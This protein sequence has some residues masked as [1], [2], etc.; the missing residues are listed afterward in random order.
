MDEDPAKTRLS[1]ESSTPDADYTLQDEGATIPHGADDTVAWSGN[2]DGSLSLGDKRA[3]P[4]VFGRYENLHPL[5]AGGA[6]VVYEAYDRNLDRQVALKAL[7]ADTDISDARKARFVGEARVMA[8]LEHP[9][10]VPVHE[11]NEGGTGRMYFTMKR[12]RGVTL[13]TIIEGLDRREADF[14]E[15]YPRERLIDIFQSICDAIGFAHDKGYIHRD[16]KPENILVGDF[17]EVQ[18]MDWG[19][20]KRVGEVSP[21]DEDELDSGDGLGYRTIVGTVAG[22]PRYMSPEQGRG[23]E[24]D[25]RSDL[26]SLGLILYELLTQR[27]AIE[28]TT[29]EKILEKVKTPNWIP[30]RERCPDAEIPRELEA[31]CMHCLRADKAHRY[32]SVMELL[33]DIQRYRHGEPVSVYQE[34]WYQL[35]WKWCR[36][37]PVVSASVFSVVMAVIVLLV[38]F[39]LARSIQSNSLMVEGN[40]YRA[41][42]D[43]AFS[44]AITVLGDLELVRAE[45]VAREPVESEVR[46]ARQLEGLETEFLNNYEKAIVF[47]SQAARFGQSDER[48]AAMSSIY[49]NRF[50]FARLERDVKSMQQLHQLLQGWFRDQPD[51]LTSEAQALLDQFA[52]GVAGL[53]GCRVAAPAGVSWTLV[54][55]V[56]E[57]GALV[58]GQALESDE[59]GLYT[60]LLPGAYILRVRGGGASSIMSFRL[61]HAEQKEIVLEM[62]VAAPEGMVFIPAGRVQ[63]LSA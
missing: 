55:L 9:N 16:L 10:I 4:G 6:G 38:S 45:Q 24:V 7:H 46:L 40:R 41:V 56:D 14:V 12:V 18:V 44:R 26:Y 34:P 15:A 25:H 54:P 63:S 33:A 2:V 52:D 22:T 39:G 53:G 30:P 60:S 43:E 42:G 48:R 58:E 13:Q 51:A 21:A 31:I 50:Q 5:G 36:R 20:Q 27:S 32:D 35:A 3:V 11:I 29:V 62:P 8:K 47:Y 17:G 57:D 1:D 59:G 61:E 23:E 19:L 28:G 37:H 49:A